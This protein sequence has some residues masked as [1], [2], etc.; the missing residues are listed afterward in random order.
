MAR[1]PKP[2]P[3]EARGPLNVMF[4]ITSMPVGGQE[5][6]LAQLVKGIDRDRFRP[7]ITCLKD[8]GELGERLAG[9]VS[10]HAN[11]IGGKYDVG[12]VGRLAQLFVEQE[13][14]AVVTVGAGDK[15]FWGRLAAKRARVPAIISAI[16]STGWPD[17]IGRLNRMLTPIT[18]AFVAVAESHG[19][20]L[21]DQE[22]F[23]QKKVAVIPNGIDVERF[24][25]NEEARQQVRAEM[26]IANGAP[27]CGIVAALRPEK[28]HLLFLRAA[29]LVLGHQPDAHFVIIGDGPEREKLE[30]AAATPQ[31]SGRVH[32]LGNRRDTPALLSA[33]DCFALTSHIEA[34]PVSILEAM[35]ARLPV[36]A[37]NVGSIHESVLEG[38]TGFLVDSG[39]AKG[40]SER[41]TQ[42]FARR[43]FAQSL[44]AAGRQ[45]VVQR[46]SLD[47]MIDGYQ[48]L[49]ES[50]YEQKAQ[51]TRV[52]L[53][54]SLL[55]HVHAQEANAV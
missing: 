1:R 44:G 46:A 17:Q 16:H 55:G 48:R 32:F 54:G 41:I 25:F 15:M 38:E 47:S 51:G 26:G 52:Q 10:V 43:D 50:I 23:P 53:P 37:T 45:R 19:S 36:V 31:L 18:D 8:E 2:V 13:V 9:E 28:N 5:V 20:Y 34:S 35:A 42:L 11:M 21:I 12:V 3:L 39:D 7:S 4:L 33:M 49:I 6:L 14:D 40:I 22:H 27:C 29:Q 30:V 24:D